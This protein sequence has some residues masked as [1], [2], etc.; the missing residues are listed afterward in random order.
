MRK[1]LI[2]GGLTAAAVAAVIGVAS[3][4]SLGTVAA[5]T[6]GYTSS[7]IDS[8]QQV[9]GVVYNVSQTADDSLTSV[10]ITFDSN[11]PV[12]DRIQVGFGSTAFVNCDDTHTDNTT[13]DVTTA[14]SSFTCALSGQ[15]V[16]GATK[17]RLLVTGS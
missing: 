9:T 4:N 1:I 2:A 11:V 14:A 15:S 7:S 10:T 16:T 12:G 5:Q 3:T 8:P 13:G 6:V 17:F